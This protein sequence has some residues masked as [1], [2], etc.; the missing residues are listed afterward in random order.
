MASKYEIRFKRRGK[1]E[2]VMSGYGSLDA[3]ALEGQAIADGVDLAPGTRL[4]VH[5]VKAGTRAKAKTGA[6]KN[7]AKAKAKKAA[8][9]AKSSRRYKGHTIRGAKAPYTVEPY[10]REFRTLAAARKWLDGHVRRESLRANPASV[11]VTAPPKPKAVKP[12]TSGVVRRATVQRSNPTKAKPLYERIDLS[13]KRVAWSKATTT[14]LRALRNEA[15]LHGDEGLVHKI[16]AAL[17]R[18]KK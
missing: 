15:R 14:E 4:E 5:P 1:T 9:R 8:S 17:K 13:A 7:P 18:R 11:R 6:K 16:D 3:A 2:R 10:G 12:G